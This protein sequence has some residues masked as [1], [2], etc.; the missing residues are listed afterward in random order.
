MG[1]DVGDYRYV[2]GH[3]LGTGVN[4]CGRL[5]DSVSERVG[6]PDVIETVG[7]WV[8]ERMSGCDS[9]NEGIGQSESELA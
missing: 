6:G 9:V 4:V 8:S 3:W 2:R 1:E 7:A 5:K